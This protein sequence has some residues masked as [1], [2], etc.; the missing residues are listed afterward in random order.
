MH[1]IL[2]PNA[3]SLLRTKVEIFRC[4]LKTADGFYEI[5]SVANSRV[6]LVP[7]GSQTQQFS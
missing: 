1:S 7:H 4:V 3:I 5:S 2:L 6:F